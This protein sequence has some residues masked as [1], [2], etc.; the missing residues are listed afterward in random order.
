MLC[1]LRACLPGT[2]T[3]APWSS[4]CYAADWDSLNHVAWTTA[5]MHT[6]RASL[7]WLQE[8]VSMLASVQLS[9]EQS[10]A[11][12]RSM[13]PLVPA[14]ADQ[15]HR[16]QTQVSSHRCLVLVAVSSWAVLQF[17]KPSLEI[18]PPNS[19][20]L[21]VTLVNA[22]ALPLQARATAALHAA[23]LQLRLEPGC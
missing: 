8:H 4:S 9:V 6:M 3:P 2:A 16:A 18:C 20:S 17:C 15:P 23:A 1:K 12:P 21:P 22:L 19:T 11:W 7:L 13:H 5:D 10:Q 14:Q